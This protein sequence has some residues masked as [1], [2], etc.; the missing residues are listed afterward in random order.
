MKQT[1]SRPVE[2]E[3]RSSQIYKTLKSSGIP[4]ADKI[5]QGL[6][7][8]AE[9][10]DSALGSIAPAV[11][12]SV[13][14]QN[15]SPQSHTQSTAP[16]GGQ[17]FSGQRAGQT[18]P[19][20]RTAQTAGVQGKGYPYQYQYTYPAGTNKTAPGR[21]AAPGQP[22]PGQAAYPGRKPAGVNR[23][24]APQMPA[25]KLVRKGS[26]AKFYITGAA[27]LLYAL[28]FPLYEVSHF[29]VFGLVLAGVFLL[30]GKLFRGKKEFVP[31][32]PVKPKEKEAPKQEEKPSQTGNPEVDKII[33]EGREYLKKLR[34][35][36]NAIPDESL[37]EC[38][39]RMERASADIFRF[40][41]DHPEKAPQIRKF[42][43]YYLPTTLKL[44]SSYQRL[45]SQSV[46]G[47]N[48]TSTMFNIA[49]MM[50]TV[51]AAFEKQLDSLFT[52]EAMD[53]SADISVFE[54]LLKQEGFVEEQ[55]EEKKQ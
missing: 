31:I 13:G 40:V 44:L 27:A 14:V 36:N 48:I 28:N 37:S 5:A 2:E 8:A 45:S 34:A 32:E 51:A 22:V 26:P 3:F 20:G 35:A 19:P 42:M 9:G 33:D 4:V 50:H 43:N 21:Q 53:V 41:A 7:K 47:E 16:T 1:G 39:D 46:R 49:G 24:P 6:G 30:S 10:L 17:P 52:D 54:T 15:G 23:A 55:K 11:K 29:I 38:I 12:R 18:P 25:M